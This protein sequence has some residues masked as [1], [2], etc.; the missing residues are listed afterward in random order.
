M[1]DLAELLRAEPERLGAEVRQLGVGRFRREEPDAGPL[2]PRVFREDELRA[3]L[4]LE[5]ERRRL[6]A[7]L[8]D[9]EEL[10]PPRARHRADEEPE[11]AIVGRK[12]EAL[13]AP[14]RAA[15]PTPLECA[16][17]WVERLQRG[18]VCRAGFRDRKR[19]HGVVQLAPP[20]L[21]LRELR[22]MRK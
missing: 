1:D 19:R 8:A 6:R 18:D 15:E 10:E 7:L 9:R 14:L 13:A 20:R 11:V 2:L 16:E 5:S 21:H 3:A 22:H 12:E 4:E 17:R